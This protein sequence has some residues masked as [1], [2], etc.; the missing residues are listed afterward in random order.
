[1][2]PP[3]LKPSDFRR[4]SAAAALASAAAALLCK[5]SRCLSHSASDALY[6]S[7]A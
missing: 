6:D 7:S 5:P 1:M 4:S 2:L 3:S